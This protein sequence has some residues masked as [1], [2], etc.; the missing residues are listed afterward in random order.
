M[1]YILDF[2]KS[3]GI[4]LGTGL[5]SADD[6]ECENCG[7]SVGDRS[8]RCQGTFSEEDGIALIKANEA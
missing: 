7:A 4:L 6:P 8:E 1:D 5:G 3:C 2:C